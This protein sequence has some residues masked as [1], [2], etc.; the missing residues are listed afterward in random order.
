[1][2]DLLLLLVIGWC[3]LQAFRRPWIGLLCWTWISIMNPHQLSWSVR[4]LPVAA[5]V[6]GA[7]LLGLLIT[8]D[9][10]DF[11]TTRETITL[12]LFMA[13]M[14]I[15]LPFSILFEPSFELWKRVMKIDL[16]ILVA[17]LV[18]H[19]KRHAMLLVWVLVVSIGFY[20]VKGGLFTL[21][22]GGSYRVWGPD[23]TYISGNNEV[24]L[25]IVIT[26]PLMRFLQMQMQG[27]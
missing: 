10:R 6:G 24:A 3:C 2:R 27:K 23:N 13:W 26:I 20:G 22:T 19:S 25:A 18:L 12:M 14:C 17:L 11:T 9:R 8:Q 21:A 16:M 4:S 7:S 15:T 5:A 1:M